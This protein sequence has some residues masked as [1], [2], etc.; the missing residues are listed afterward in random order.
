M[1]PTPRTSRLAPARAATSVCRST[2]LQKQWAIL[3]FR[4]IRQKPRG[5]AGKRPGEGGS[6]DRQREIEAEMRVD[7]Y[8]VMRQG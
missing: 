1:S 4:Q 8:V 6:Q 5:Q 2:L 3:G 7:R